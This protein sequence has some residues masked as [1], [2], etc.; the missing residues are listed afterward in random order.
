MFGMG[1]TPGSTV[2]VYGGRFA[3]SSVTPCGAVVG[4]ANA[5]LVATTTADQDGRIELSL[6][7]PPRVAGVAALLQTVEPSGCLVGELRSQQ[8]Q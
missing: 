7:L 4:I 3:G 2:Q 8:L 6:A 5:V 1:F